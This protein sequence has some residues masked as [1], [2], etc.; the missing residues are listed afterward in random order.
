MKSTLTPESRKVF[1]LILLA[2]GL[3]LI[4]GCWNVLY[5]GI[6]SDEGFYALAARSVSE[7][8]VPYRDFGYPQMPLLPYINGFLMRF[9]GFG[10]FQQRAI[11]GL[12]AAFTVL[13]VVRWIARRTNLIWA[14]GFGALLS[15]SATWM[16]FVHLGKTY[17]L[18]GLVIAAAVW[19]FTEWEAGVRKI[20]LLAFLATIGIGCR[21]TTI[22]FF[23]VLWLAAA[24][25]LPVRSVRV[26][27]LAAAGSLLW[28]TI[29]LLPFYLAAPEAA[30]FWTMELHH[31]SVQNRT[32]NLPWPVIAALAPALWL[33]LIFSI[34]HVAVTRRFPERNEM[35]ILLATSLALTVNL[36]P[37]G[38]YEEY[39]VPFLPALVLLAA[40]GLWRAG[41]TIR[42]LRRPII[43]P[44][45]IAIN[46]AA[47]VA[48]LWGR[49]PA[50]RH[51]NLSVLLPLNAAAYDSTL[52]TRLAQQTRVV[53]EYLS[54]D[55]PFIG[56]DILLAVEAHRIVPRILRMGAFTGTIDF[57]PAQAA[58][59]SLAT[60]AQLE[61]YFKDPATPF[62]A[63]YKNGNMNYAWSMPTFRNPAKQ[64]RQRWLEIFHRDFLVAYE[65]NDSFLLVRKGAF[66]VER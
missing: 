58:R 33:A 42:W 48:L 9:I 50:D 16:A 37:S 3:H 28:P 25:E 57:A 45:L 32:W 60:F 54:P 55:Q 61:G 8:D 41:A 26:L 11:N 15:L 17:A 19:V 4:F 40:L 64:V 62:L 51:S 53:Q 20:C 36:L 31:L 21:L 46:L 2:A 13:L 18:A 49:M 14:L 30:Y 10:L 12:W 52:P 44:G 6:N 35:V 29:F 22:P 24:I 43:H 66:P 34:T 38:V 23:A 59:M 5:S 47:G 1:Y 65:D 56:P 39:A 27:S 7:G 63:F